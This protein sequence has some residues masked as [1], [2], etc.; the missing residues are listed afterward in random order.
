MRTTGSG[1]L[2]WERL[3]LGRQGFP[4]ALFCY[5]ST[6]TQTLILKLRQY[7]I[8]RENDTIDQHDQHVTMDQH[9]QHGTLDQHYHASIS[10]EL[11]GAMDQHGSMD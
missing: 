1:K 2:F 5:F 11:T 10:C 7:G 9:D 6:V 4:T 8:Q 3:I